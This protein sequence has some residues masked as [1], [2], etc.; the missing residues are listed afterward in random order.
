M[1]DVDVR[2]VPAYASMADVD[3]HIVPAY[4]SMADVDVRIVPAWRRECPCL[5]DRVEAQRPECGSLPE[6]AVGGDDVDVCRKDSEGSLEKAIHQFTGWS[7]SVQGT[8]SSQSDSQGLIRSL[9]R[10]LSL[11]P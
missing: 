3:V 11:N 10:H 8:D 1:A 9:R 7:G 4:A 6:A 5:I 2:I